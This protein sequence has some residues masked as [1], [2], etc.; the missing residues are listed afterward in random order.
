[1]IFSSF[2]LCLFKRLFIYYII[3]NTADSPCPK[4]Q[5]F[6]APSKKAGKP[7]LKFHLIFLSDLHRFMDGPDHFH[8]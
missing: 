3:K 6:S 7:A 2:T 5:V 4:V 1:M 8:R